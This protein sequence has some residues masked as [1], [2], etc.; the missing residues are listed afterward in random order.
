MVLPLPLGVLSSVE[1]SVRDILGVELPLDA[2]DSVDAAA[3]LD[4]AVRSFF[5]VVAVDMVGEDCAQDLLGN[6]GG[7]RPV[8]R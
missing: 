1:L 5:L 6:K 8:A 4:T 3:A 7:P 2:G